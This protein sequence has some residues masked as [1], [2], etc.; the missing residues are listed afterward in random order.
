MI[1]QIS[2][3]KRKDGVSVED[4][5]N[6]WRTV[7][8]DLVVKLPGIRGYVQ[9]HTL[10]SGYKSVHKKREPDFDGVAEVWFDSTDEMRGNVGSDA[11]Q[12]IRDDEHNFIDRAS[13]GTLLTTFTA[14]VKR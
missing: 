5:Q 4:F 1:K 13:M 14:V 3:F 12:A 10:P 2:F 7:H 9:N 8:A 11:L 6:H